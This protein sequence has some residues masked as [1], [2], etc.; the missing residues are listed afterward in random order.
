MTHCFALVDCNN[1]YASCERLFRP[2]L[3]KKPIV[4]LSNNDGCIIARSEE[5]KLLSISMG[6]PYFQIK[7]DLR[8]KKVAVFSSNYTLY[9]DI[10]QR[11]QQ[12]LLSWGDAI[13]CYSIDESFLY[14]NQPP[15]DPYS[16]SRQ[17]RQQLIKQLK[18]P[19]GVG[20]G[21]SKTLAK[22][23]NHIAKRHSQSGCASLLTQHQRN[24]WLP[25][26][27]IGEVW[28]IGHRLREKLQGYGFESVADLANADHLWIRKKFS[29]TLEKTVRELQG[30]ACLEM[31]PQIES[32]KQIISSR[33]FCKRLTELADLQ[34]AITQYTCRAA[35]K[36]RQQNSCCGEIGV[37][38]TTGKNCDK[39]YTAAKSIRLNKPINDSR[40]LSEHAQALIHELFA[41]GYQYQKASVWLSDIDPAS[42]NQ[43]QLLE[44][45]ADYRMHNSQQLMKTLDEINQRFGRGS[46]KLAAESL[47]PKWAMKRDFCSPAYTTNWQQL[48]KANAN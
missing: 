37:H 4:V 40:I 26:L 2:D 34:Q 44:T 48:P 30:Q 8:Q 5:A 12:I 18:M 35:E 21:S 38:L 20:F 31:E 42:K 39:P 1:F 46:L 24:L 3:D 29:V 6:S 47:Q 14:F 25:Q 17:I 28:G 11:V 7:N 10:S 33:S 23:A 9:G 13:E 43:L 16:L 36:L 22:L 15:A 41:P 32:R 45:S 27:P 19:V